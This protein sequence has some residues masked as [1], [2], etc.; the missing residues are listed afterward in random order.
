LSYLTN[1]IVYFFGRDETN[2]MP[3]SI[4]DFKSSQTA[5]RRRYINKTA[6]WAA[7]KIHWTRMWP[8]ECGFEFVESRTDNEVI[9]DN[10]AAHVAVQHERESAEH[11]LFLQRTLVFEKNADSLR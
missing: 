4:Q 5:S 10:S 2:C 7:S 3:I 6:H 11:P 8:R 9:T 1:R